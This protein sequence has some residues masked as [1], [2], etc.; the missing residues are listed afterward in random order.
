[1]ARIRLRLADGCLDLFAGAGGGEAFL[2]GFLRIRQKALIAI[3]WRLS[4]LCPQPP[5]STKRGNATLHRDTSTSHTDHIVRCEQ[6]CG[7]L[8][9]G[10]LIASVWMCHAQTS[11]VIA[12]EALFDVLTADVDE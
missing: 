7:S 9:Q 3:H 12:S 4:I 5:W 2:P 8:S 6:K 11:C 10:F 1:M